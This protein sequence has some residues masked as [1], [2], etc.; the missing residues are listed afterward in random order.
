MKS[1]YSEGCEGFRKVD[2]EKFKILTIDQ[3][4][5]SNVIDVLEFIPCDNELKRVIYC[6]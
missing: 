2:E 5:S 4:Y 3:R 1:E 6:L